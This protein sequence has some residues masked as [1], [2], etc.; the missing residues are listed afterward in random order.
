MSGQRLR[1]TGAGQMAL[2]VALAR[3]IENDLRCLHRMRGGIGN[4]FAGHRGGRIPVAPSCFSVSI[5]NHG[6]TPGTPALWGGVTRSCVTSLCNHSAYSV[7][8]TGTPG[9]PK[10]RGSREGFF[11][12]APWP[13]ILCC[14][15][16]GHICF[17]G[18]PGVPGVPDRPYHCDYLPFRGSHLEHLASP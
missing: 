11:P 5:C 6:G 8:H 16:L 2:S 15:N 1:G 9:T 3:W 7:C 17:G 13:I 18:V 4:P 14:E 12:P 10:I